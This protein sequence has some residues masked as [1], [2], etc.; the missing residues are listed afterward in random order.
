MR[1]EQCVSGL[2]SHGFC[3]GG[4][5][6]RLH[7]CGLSHFSRVQLFETPWTKP[8]Q[9]PLSR[10]FSRQEYCSGLP[11]PP[12]GNLPD[13]GIEPASHLSPALADGFF[14]TSITWVIIFLSTLCFTN[15]R[16]TQKLD[17]SSPHAWSG[18]HLT[19]PDLECWPPLTKGPGPV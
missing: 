15:F 10:G 18:A 16:K 17:S 14:T 6:T 3:L 1:Q 5:I 7:T 4:L 11:C 8:R 12:L 9:P 2:D 19:G 13:P